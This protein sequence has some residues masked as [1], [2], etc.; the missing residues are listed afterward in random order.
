MLP[1]LLSHLRSQ[2]YKGIPLWLIAAGGSLLLVGAAFFGLTSG[3]GR[4]ASIYKAETSG[5]V[6]ALDIAIKLGFTLVCLYLSMHVLKRLQ[7]R[8]RK[9]DHKQLSVIRSI[10]L[11]GKQSVHLIQA[12]E[13]TFLI[14]ATDQ[15]LNLLA[16]VDLPDVQ[17]DEQPAAEAQNFPRVFARLIGKAEA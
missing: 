14:G 4:G 1:D 9:P 3:G 16:D 11:N 2:K 6:L 13:Q 17:E 12:G 15:S 10:R 7:T 8:P 5:G